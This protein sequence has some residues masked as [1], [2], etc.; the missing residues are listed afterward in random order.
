L[1]LLIKNSIYLHYLLTYLTFAV[2]QT[3]TAEQCVGAARTQVKDRIVPA[4]QW[5]HRQQVAILVPVLFDV[6]HVVVLLA[7]VDHWYILAERDAL[8]WR[9]YTP[10]SAA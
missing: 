7:R 10:T 6:G 2:K 8:T 4:L 9:P 3:Y 1:S 5:R